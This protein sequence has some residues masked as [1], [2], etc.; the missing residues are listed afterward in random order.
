MLARISLLKKKKEEEEKDRLDMNPH[1]FWGT[2][3]N[4]IGRERKRAAAKSSFNDGTGKFMLALPAL[5]S[6]HPR[7]VLQVVLWQVSQD[8]KKIGIV[9]FKK[10]PV[11][12][13]FT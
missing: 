2:L 8:L 1:G 6:G 5:R 4:L 3:E 12:S 7:F 11:V 13:I 10:G 9:L